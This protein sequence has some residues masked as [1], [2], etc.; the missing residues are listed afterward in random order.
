VTT[1]QQSQ[2]R[3]LSLAQFWACRWAVQNWSVCFI[4]VHFLMLVVGDRFQRKSSS[5][6]RNAINME[7]LKLMQDL[8][9]CKAKKQ[10]QVC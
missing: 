4:Q 5:E 8:E 9:A 2:T 6:D 7:N 3:S 1:A 10:F